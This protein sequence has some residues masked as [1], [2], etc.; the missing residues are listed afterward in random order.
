MGVTGAR[1]RAVLGAGHARPV[2]VWPEA[3]PGPSALTAGF[4]RWFGTPPSGLWH[5]PGRLA[6]MGEHTAASEGPALYV[7]LPWGVTAAV[8]TAE[9]P[10]VRVATVNGPLSERHRAVREVTSVVAAAREAGLLKADRG[11]RVVLGSDLPEHS[12]LGHSAAVGA[13]VAL[14]LSD[15]AGTT[16]PDGL[17]LDLRVGLEARSGHLVRVNRRG[18]RT[19]LFPF[20]LEGS[21]LRLVLVDTGALPRRDLRPVRAAELARAQETLGPLRAVQDLPAALRRIQNPALRDRVEFAVTET[22]R[23]NAAVGLLR[24]GRFGEVGPILS[25]SHLSLR[26]FD[27]PLPAVETAVEAAAR[28]GARG[29]RMSGWAG[30]SYALVPSERVENVVSG[31]REA[32]RVRGRPEPRVR[33]ALPSEGARRVD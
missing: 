25:A 12:S 15:L 17:P 3:S 2:G 5:A 20:D 11:V 6:L 26:R 19:A 18:G 33:V 28:S 10:G 7:C 9:D 30:T 14:A 1:L 27:L 22:H 32:F 13:A 23:L 29:A 24:E 21:D 4:T 31:I 16:P 8:G